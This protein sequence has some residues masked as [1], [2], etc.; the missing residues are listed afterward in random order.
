[1]TKKKGRKPGDCGIQKPK[2]VSRREWA[3]V[4]TAAETPNRM[5]SEKFNG[6]AKVE[7]NVVRR[8]RDRS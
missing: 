2:S 8:N 1:M 5:L 7:T 4:S 6:F 3:T